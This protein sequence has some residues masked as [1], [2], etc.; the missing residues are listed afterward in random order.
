MDGYAE[1]W[2]RL[3]AKLAI[4]RKDQIALIDDG[5]AADEQGRI[6]LYFRWGPANRNSM[7]PRSFATSRIA[8]SAH[9]CI[10][11]LDHLFC[12]GTKQYYHIGND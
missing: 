9:R 7:P 12:Y 4:A 10:A 3:T 11:L 6:D 1:T 2:G 5:T 8:G